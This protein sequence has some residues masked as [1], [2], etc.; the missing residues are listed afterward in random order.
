MSA[1]NASED[2]LFAVGTNGARSVIYRI[3]NLTGKGYVKLIEYE[4]RGQAV[5]IKFYVCEVVDGY[6]FVVG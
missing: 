2:L 6:P 4:S 5:Y 1:E 3:D